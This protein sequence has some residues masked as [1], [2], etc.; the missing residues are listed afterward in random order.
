MP[1]RDRVDRRSPPRPGEIRGRLTKA[2]ATLTARDP[3][4]SRVTAADLCRLADVSRNSLY[5]YHTPILAALRHDQGVK[6]ARTRARRSAERHRRENAAL[7]DRLTK[8]VALVD[9]YFAA[10]REVTALL[11]RRDRELAELRTRLH[12]Q[13]AIISAPYL[14]A[15]SLHVNSECAVKEATGRTPESFRRKRQNDVESCFMPR[16]ESK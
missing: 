3:G 13:P 2:L 16:K 15:P 4:Q 11:K 14:A 6:S 10:Y 9:H 7:R 12:S 5:R 1:T 8:V